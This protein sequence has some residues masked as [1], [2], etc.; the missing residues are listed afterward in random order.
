MRWNIISILNE[1]NFKN[2]KIKKKKENKK[3][4]VIILNDNFTKVLMVENNY[5][6]TKN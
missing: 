5:T 1:D 4:G 2:F 3:N 6:Y